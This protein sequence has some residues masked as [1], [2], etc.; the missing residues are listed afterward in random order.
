MGRPSVE[1]AAKEIL[2]IAVRDQR[3]TAGAAIHAGTVVEG[4]SYLPWNQSDLSPAL[5]FAQSKGWITES[6]Q[7]TGVGFAAAP[8]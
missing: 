1:D 3:L 5:A 8:I 2:R 7:L 4:F 6:G